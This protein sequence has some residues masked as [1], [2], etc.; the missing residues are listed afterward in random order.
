VRVVAGSGGYP[1]VERQSSRRCWE[2]ELAA[3]LRR[4]ACDSGGKALLEVD[5]AAASGG[6]ASPAQGRSA[7]SPAGWA[8]GVAQG[9]GARDMG[10]E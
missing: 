5:L 3:V 6:A 1:A 10:E 2:V 7:S 4:R 8:Q 9:R